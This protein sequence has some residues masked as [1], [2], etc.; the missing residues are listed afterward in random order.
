MI[1]EIEASGLALSQFPDGQKAANWGFVVRNELVVALGEILIVAEADENS[2]SMRSVEYALKMG[3]PIFALPQPLSTS[4][5]TNRLLAD[6]QALPI[7]DVEAFADR[8]GVVP[9]SEEVE[10]DDF[11]YFCQKS[12]TVDAAVSSYGERVFEAEL[13]GRIRIENGRIRLA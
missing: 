3:K 2:G 8:Y 11:F 10:K 12:P 4:R 1:A 9:T 6:G 13:E 7:Y 5:G